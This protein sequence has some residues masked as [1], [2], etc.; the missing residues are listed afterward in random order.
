MRYVQIYELT[1]DAEGRQ[2]LRQRMTDVLAMRPLLELTELYFTD[3][4]KFAVKTIV[5]RTMLL[6]AVLEDQLA[7]EATARKAALKSAKKFVKQNPKGYV[8]FPDDAVAEHRRLAHPHEGHPL[9][10]GVAWR[11]SV[12]PDEDKATTE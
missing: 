11:P 4:Y 7:A 8:D 12:R 6:R 10:G 1:K 5:Y 9:D 2:A 3:A